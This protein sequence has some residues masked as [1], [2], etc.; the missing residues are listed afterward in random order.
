MIKISSKNCSKVLLS[1]QL[2]DIRWQQGYLF[3][4]QFNLSS[5]YITFKRLYMINYPRITQCC[6]K[7]DGQMIHLGII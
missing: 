1:S 2:M 6:V 4:K 7:N 5:K 3:F